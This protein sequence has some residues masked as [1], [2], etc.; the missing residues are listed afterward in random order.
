M[1]RGN[2]KLCLSEAELQDSHLLPRAIYKLFRSDKSPNPNPILVTSQNVLQTSDR[3]KAHLLCSQCE[4]LLNAKGER[5]TLPLLA[6]PNGKFPFFDLLLQRPPDCYV[7]RTAAFAASR[8]ANIDVGSLSH[9]AIGVFWKASVHD[10][11]K[12]NGNEQ[13][14]L[15]PYGELLRSYLLADG[16]LRLPDGIALTVAVLPPPVKTILAYSPLV[17]DKQ[18]MIRTF[19]FYVPGFLFALSVGRSLEPETCFVGNPLHPI[20]LRNLCTGMRLS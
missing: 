4:E 20:L 14:R 7:D 2:C 9:F 18:E 6:K 15:G 3:I 17:G 12:N 11:T 5:W 16:A 19:R 13:I 10:W 8:N 1:I